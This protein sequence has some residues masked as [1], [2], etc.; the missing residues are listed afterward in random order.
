MDRVARSLVVFGLSGVLGACALGAT[1]GLPAFTGA[2]VA[3]NDDDFGGISASLGLGRGSS[4]YRFED[5]EILQ[6]TMYYVDESYVDPTRISYPDMYAAAL[7][8]VEQKV[9]TCMFR[10]EP[11]GTLLHIDVG[12][13]HTVLEVGKL[14]SGQALH[15]ELTRVADVIEKGLRP[16]DVPTDDPD[17]NPLAQ[18]E[19]AMVNGILGTLD[20]HSRL[21]PPEAAKVMDTDN[22]GEFGGLGITIKEDEGKLIVD[23]PLPNT[24]AM[25]AGLQANDQIVRIDGESTI[26]MDIDEAVGKLRGPLKTP[27]DI[28]IMRDGLT[29]PMKVRI[30]REKIPLHP[31][32]SQLL[33]TPKGNV[34]YIKI[35]GYHEKVKEQLDAELRSLET[36]A[37]A[38]G[39]SGLILDHRG[40]PGGYLNQAE[41]TADTFL[42]SGV[43]V[44]Q[45]DGTGK[46]IE[47]YNAT[48]SREPSYP[49]AVLVNANSASASEIVAGALRNNERAVVIGDRSYGKGSVQNLH[50]MADDSKLKLTISQ[51]LTPGERSI[52]A[53]GIPADIEL[54]PSV[55]EPADPKKNPDG[56]P[57]VQLYWIER[58]KR[59]ADADKHLVQ[60]TA[61]M[62]Q[63]AYTLRYLRPAELK[64]RKG[65][66]LD[67]QEDFEVQFAKDV[68]LASPSPRRADVLASAAGVV[69]RYTKTETHDIQ[70]AF[71]GLKLD[72]STG[73]PA[74]KPQLD[75]RLDLGPDGALVAGKEEDIAI[76]VTNTGTEPMYQV[77]AIA[78]FDDDY[79]AREFFFGKLMPGEKRSWT[80][81]V[82][83]D[84]GHP[85]ELLPTR[86]EVRDQSGVNVMV[87]QARIPV[88]GTPLP[89]LEWSASVRDGD[90]D[91]QVEVG[92]KI[93]VDLAI[94]NAGTGPTGD[95]FA[96][97]K[98]KSGRSIDLVRASLLPGSVVDTNGQPCKV[99]E[100]GVENGQVVGDAAT[101]NGRIEKH[102][103]PKYATG[104]ERR[105]APGQTWTGSFEFT[106]KDASRPLDFELDLG[107]AD[108]FD[109]G[110][111]MREG[112][113]SYFSQKEKITLLPNSPIPERLRSAPGANTIT[114][115]PPTIQVTVQPGVVA[116]RSQATISG[117]VSDD[118]GL[119]HVMVYLGDDKVFFQ[120]AV[121]SAHLKS[122]PFTAD[123]ALK[124]GS[125]TISILATDEDGYTSTRSVATF[126]V[127]PSVAKVDEVTISPRAELRRP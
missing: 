41:A 120:G 73:A 75:V 94:R 78:T 100:A 97:L 108:A 30:V 72:W 69:A 112:F 59:E 107:D 38:G 76:E 102:D 39:L 101:A 35:S 98:N 48:R 5:L 52:Q 56:D 77:S 106:V 4:V 10:R 42:P 57:N 88:Q 123:L 127:D 81:P 26:N 46:Q 51:Y 3:S 47:V 20:P 82:R 25:K 22:Q 115:I 111:V 44:S 90:A 116:E 33:K 19:Y 113:Y 122:M 62:E 54:V 14:D 13:M 96:R 109:H 12:E 61:R 29:E 21:L 104:C 125:N 50:P 15:Q 68:L 55:V 2:K 16:G 95:V 103:P 83:L 28:E 32:E 6:T 70:E 31:V 63:P 45:V 110:T 67:L 43:I 7:K 87:E 85:T 24:P 36:Q 11:N 18:V 118:E 40:N 91:N 80:A 66:E 27:V 64:T 124:P 60:A 117:V 71:A 92:D 37:G 23:Y 65:A 74:K 105:I 79:S 99:L 93:S 49:I 34:G 119:E 114:A 17:E 126:W 9:P 58:V 84:T 1:G 121:S 8:A 89:R 86:I 53:V